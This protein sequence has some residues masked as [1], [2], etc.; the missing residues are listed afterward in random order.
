MYQSKYKAV[1]HTHRFTGE[2]RVFFQKRVNGELKVVKKTHPR[3]NTLVTGYRKLTNL[4]GGQ[5]TGMIPVYR[6]EQVLW[7]G[8]PCEDQLGIGRDW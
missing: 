3:G 8:Q 5:M 7:D 6:D 4:M 2:Q 1:I